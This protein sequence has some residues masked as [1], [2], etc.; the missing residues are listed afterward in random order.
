MRRVCWRVMRLL[1]WKRLSWNDQY[2][3]G[4]WNSDRRSA[5]AI[6]RVIDLC[7]GGKLIEFGCGYGELPHFLP[8][9]TFSSYVG[10]DISDVAIANARQL[11]KDR[12][13]A[14]CEF[15]QMDMAEWSG[16]SGVS[17][18][19]IEECLYYLK[20]REQEDFLQVCCRSLA[21]QGR[22]LVVVH[23]GVKHAHTLDTCRRVCAVAEEEVIS[24]RI[25][26]T[27]TRKTSREES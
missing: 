18:I 4:E 9:G 26:L 25:Y 14:G 6:Q 11:A 22:I 5:N 13:L 3:R 17:L 2:R 1:G 16:D 20:E 7:R 12:G 21:P 24:T 15:C 19:H 27:L 10:L 23:D 8:E